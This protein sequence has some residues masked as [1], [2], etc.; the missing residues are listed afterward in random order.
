MNDEIRVLDMGT[1]SA[2]RSQVIYHA[3]AGAMKADTPDTIILVSP[4]S[5]YAC[6]GLHQELEKEVD[7][8]YLREAGLPVYRREVGGGAVYLDSGQVFA[9][10]IFHKGRLPAS[11]EERYAL[12]VRPLVETYRA[13]GIPAV[14]RPVND[15]HVNGRKIGGT[16]AAEIEGA[17]VVVGS[18]MLDFDTRTMSRILK[19]ASEKMRDKI[20]SSL[21]D[22]MTTMRR[23]LGTLPEVGMVKEVYLRAC[24]AA[25]GRRL[26]P[27]SVRPD[28]EAEAEGIDRRFLSP[29][30]LAQKTG[31]VIDGIRIHQD[32]SLHESI[33]KAQGG[34]IRVTLRCRG[35]R[36]DDITISGDFTMIPSDALSV[37][38]L[39]LAGAETQDVLP[40]I[41][42]VYDE[43]SVQSPGLTPENL[44]NAIGKI[45][46]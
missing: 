22:Y 36:I 7:L 21:E 20:F 14:H 44:S 10:W 35:G 34:L 27:G 38:E 1:V 29:E 19:V 28:E 4:A 24:G 42:A 41:R 40:R 11:V 37:L 2:L 6:I 45:P 13:F 16:G 39:R 26:V 12:F 9:Q 43:M 31:R 8:E 25:L 46:D 5:P 3:V 30:W 23:E 33:S 15:I 32:V 17:D 18:I